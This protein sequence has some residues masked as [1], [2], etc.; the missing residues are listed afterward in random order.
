MSIADLSSK[1][2]SRGVGP[3]IPVAA[4]QECDI[5]ACIRRTFVARA[6]TQHRGRRSTS[7]ILEGEVDG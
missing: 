1:G 6:I 7:L 4:D 3:D 2:Q 5:I